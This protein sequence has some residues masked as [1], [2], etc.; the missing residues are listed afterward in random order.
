MIIFFKKSVL[1]S[2]LMNIAALCA[3]ANHSNK[4]AAWAVSKLLKDENLCINTDLAFDIHRLGK[5]FNPVEHT[6]YILL[7]ETINNLPASAV[8]TRDEI[9]ITAADTLKDVIITPAP[10]DIKPEE[11]VAEYNVSV[12]YIFK[13]QQPVQTD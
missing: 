11:F 12:E 8:I 5:M 4:D 7:G 1:S 6:E 13:P 9:K 2:D 3:S 10:N